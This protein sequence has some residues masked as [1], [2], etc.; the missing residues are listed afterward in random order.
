MMHLLSD[1]VNTIPLSVRTNEFYNKLLGI[2]K[3]IY[4]SVPVDVSKNGIHI[5][6]LIELSDEEIKALALSAKAIAAQL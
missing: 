4:I 5:N 6:E 2:D 3:S 1:E